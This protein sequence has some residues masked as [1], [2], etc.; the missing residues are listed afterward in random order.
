MPVV[1]GVVERSRIVEWCEGPCSSLLYEGGIGRKAPTSDEVARGAR[2]GEMK[3][4]ER[5]EEGAREERK[6]R[7]QPYRVELIGYKRGGV[8][9]G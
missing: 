3:G 8:D 2:D 6:R 4:R 1:D 5:V 9:G 7:C